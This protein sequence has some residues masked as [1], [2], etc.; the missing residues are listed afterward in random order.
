MFG[1][2]HTYCKVKFDDEKTYWYRTND[3]GFRAGM[4]VIVP[5]TNNGLW[6]IG[7]IV[8]ATVYK[9]E[10]VPY[11]GLAERWGA[12]ST[13]IADG[14]I[15]KLNEPVD[16]QD[17]PPAS[18]MVKKLVRNVTSDS[19]CSACYASLVRA[20]Y[21]AEKEGLRT[22]GKICIGQGFAGRDIE[23]IGIGRCCS[24]SDRNVMGCPPTA[25]AILDL[26]RQ[27]GSSV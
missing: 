27:T 7:T 5:V 11:I 8:E 18:G 16:S 23:G 14:D 25:E 4:K 3:Y 13:K 26:F 15:I 22:G 19:A 1:N 2:K 6:K 10:D 9:T 17:Y 21:I 24:R 12:G 20:L